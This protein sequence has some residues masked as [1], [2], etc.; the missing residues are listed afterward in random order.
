MLMAG[1]TMGPSGGRGTVS[2]DDGVPVGVGLVAVVVVVEAGGEVKTG[3]SLLT[4]I[5]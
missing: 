3:R 5:T 1:A 2:E 4:S